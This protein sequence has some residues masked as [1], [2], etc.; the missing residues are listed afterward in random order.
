MKSTIFVLSFLAC[1]YSRASIPKSDSLIKPW[2]INKERF[3]EKFG[4]SDT[5]KALIDFWFANRKGGI[6]VASIATPFGILFGIPFFK[7]VFK[8]PASP[9]AYA[10]V[11]VFSFGLLFSIF[12]LVSLVGLLK[13]VRFSRKKLYKMIVLHQS[14]QGL[15]KNIRESSEKTM[16]RKRI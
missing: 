6:I 5:S 9:N 11:I 4:N 10:P 2:H 15:P 12:T 14:G 1:I 3:I 16:T 13:L 7:N 8:K